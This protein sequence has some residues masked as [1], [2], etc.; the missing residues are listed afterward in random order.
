MYDVIIV[1]AGVSGLSA[2][3]VA[4]EKG[5][6]VLLMEGAARVGQKLLLTG[7]GKANLSNTDMSLNYYNNDFAKVCIDESS[8]IFEFFE[9]IGLKTKVVG[10]RIYPY[11]ENATTVLNAMRKKISNAETLVNC[12]VFNIDYSGGIFTINNQYKAKNCI[13]CTGSEATKGYNSL[14]LLEKFGHKTTKL[15]PAIVALVTDTTY[16]KGLSGLRAKAELSLISDNRTVKKSEGELLFKDNGISGIVSMELSSF[17]A[18]N[19]SSYKIKVDFAPDLAES[20][21]ITFLDK[22]SLDGLLQSAI[23]LSVEKQAQ[24]LKKPIF[25]VVK[26]FEIDDVKLG[27]IRNAQVVC[28]GLEVDKFDNNMQSLLVPGLYACGEALDVD[29]DCGG[30]NLHWAFLSGIIAGENI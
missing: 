1:G 8:R 14:Y 12:E 22:N 5:L 7:N 29:G 16:I 24:E 19:P 18:R 25:K 6:K 23:A 11:S 9:L 21:I 26:G 15:Y 30:Y 20:E 17:I 4:K 10:G 2:G 13:F 27:S 28:G 3:I